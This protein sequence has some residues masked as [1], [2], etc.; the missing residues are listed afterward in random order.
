MQMPI[1]AYDPLNECR[2]AVVGG[3]KLLIT[4]SDIYCLGS[5]GSFMVACPKCGDEHFREASDYFGH[6][7]WYKCFNANCEHENLLPVRFAEIES[8]WKPLWNEVA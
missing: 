3:H 8:F 2:F 7:E 4:L 5:G 1:Y 6:P